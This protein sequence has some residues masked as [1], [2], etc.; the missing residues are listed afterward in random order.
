MPKIN[1][2]K[3]AYNLTKTLFLLLFYFT[4]KMPPLS[5]PLIKN[6]QIKMESPN[7]LYRIC[8]S[9]YDGPVENFQSYFYGLYCCC[10]PFLMT[11]TS[12][13]VILMFFPP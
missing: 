12:S 10:S 9:A 3:K 6:V 11:A 1:A 13:S 8:K 4:I 7:L 2:I 5:V